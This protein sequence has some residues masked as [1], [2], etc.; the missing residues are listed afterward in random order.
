MNPNTTAYKAAVMQARVDGADIEVRSRN[1]TIWH[2][3]NVEPAWN[4]AAM[5]YRVAL[6]R[7]PARGYAIITH[8]RD[9]HHHGRLTL[10]STAEQARTHAS[11]C[12]VESYDIIY[13]QE[14]TDGSDG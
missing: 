6:K 11:L 2:K 14:T 8:G 10:F 13:M 4:W 3:A 12:R 9:P 5:E 1:G 7:E